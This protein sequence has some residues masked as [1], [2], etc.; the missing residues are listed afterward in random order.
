MLEIWDQLRP[1]ICLPDAWLM[2][3]V[4]QDCQRWGWGDFL[5]TL[6]VRQRTDGEKN[7]VDSAVYTMKTSK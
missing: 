2:Q 5:K 4:D 7:D 3:K 1:E 6:M